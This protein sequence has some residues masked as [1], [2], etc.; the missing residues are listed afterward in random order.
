MRMCITEWGDEVLNL[1]LAALLPAENISDSAFSATWDRNGS[2]RY[3][4]MRSA[5]SRAIW[6]IISRTCGEV[7]S[8]IVKRSGAG[9][10]TGCC[11]GRDKES[12]FFDSNA[13]SYIR[14]G[15]CATCSACSCAVQSEGSLVRRKMRFWSH[16]MGA[17]ALFNMADRVVRASWVFFIVCAWNDSYVYVDFFVEAVHNKQFWCVS[18]WLFVSVQALF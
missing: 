15:S 8:F 11:A 9:A 1:S 17:K 12:S 2:T 3:E 13:A 10:E 6:R 7:R 16:A 5:S 14:I 4:C 18:R